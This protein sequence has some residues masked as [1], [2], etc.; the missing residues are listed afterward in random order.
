M[1]DAQH[2]LAGREVGWIVDEQGVFVIQGLAEQQEAEEVYARHPFYLWRIAEGR[3]R[4]RKKISY[5]V[6]RYRGHEA[7]LLRGKIVEVHRAPSPQVRNEATK[8]VDD[9]WVPGLGGA[10]PEWPYD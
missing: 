4:T 5:V 3:Y 8:R 7:G 6:V 10:A 1:I 9:H 2:P